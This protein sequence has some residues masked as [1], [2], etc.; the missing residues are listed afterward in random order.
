MTNTGPRKLISRVQRS[1][2]LLAAAAAGFALGLALGATWR[3]GLPSLPTVSAL[4]PWAGWIGATVGLIGLWYQARRARYTLSIDLVLKL[5]DRFDSPEMRATRVRAAQ[6]L[7][8]APTEG[9]TAVDD[10]LNFFEELGFL[11]D[12]RAVDAEAAWEFFYYW[13]AR[14]YHATLEYLQ[15]MEAEQPAEAEAYRHFHRL[16]GQLEP[17][18]RDRLNEEG[19]QWVP[20]SNE[21]IEDFKLAEVDLLGKPPPFRLKRRS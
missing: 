10:V 17:I 5:S 3:G 7:L 6:A 14:Y 19:Q 18:E 8:R 13:V 4:L 11:V 9:N 20:L 16:Y 15:T 21:R 2:P 1:W 12:R